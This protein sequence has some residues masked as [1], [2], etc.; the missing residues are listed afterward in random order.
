M[1]DL[2][3]YPSRRGF[4]KAT[5]AGFAL[6]GVAMSAKAAD[7]TPP[8]PLDQYERS[9]FT[10]EEWAFVMAATARLIPSEGNGPGALEARVPV[11]LDL[12]LAGRYGAASDWYMEGPHD[13][14]AEPARGWQTPLTPAEVYR[15]AIP[16]FDAWCADTYGKGFAALS[17]QDQD[18]ALSALQKGEAPLAPELREFFGILLA[19]TKEGYFADPIYGGNHD[20]QSWVYIGFPGARAAF[21]EW[22]ERH[23]V[24]YPLGP[25]SITGERA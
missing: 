19:N 23:N 21:R 24:K 9:Y 2:P 22:P 8:V 17:P 4:L 16:A 12:Q 11:F 5:A 7:K 13:P 10:A 25:V 14:G 1:T 3:G 6:S 20:M 15:Q 18:A